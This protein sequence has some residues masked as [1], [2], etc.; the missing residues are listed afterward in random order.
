MGHRWLLTRQIALVLLERCCGCSPCTCWA[1][2]PSTRGPM[3]TAP[4]E[5]GSTPCAAHLEGRH[6]SHCPWQSP[7]QQLIQYLHRLK[8]FVRGMHKRLGI[9]MSALVHCGSARCV[10]TLCSAPC[11]SCTHRWQWLPCRHAAPRVP[12][13]QWASMV[14]TRRADMQNM[15]WG[16]P[17]T[18]HAG[19]LL[20]ASHCCGATCQPDGV[21]GSCA[22]QAAV[23]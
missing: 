18:P 7:G 11:Q 3:R 1:S 16:T 9:P 17:A 6:L 2:A 13:W 14:H 8:C 10:C 15:R 4:Q 12:A 20:S 5:L 19:T 23:F 22:G 21:G